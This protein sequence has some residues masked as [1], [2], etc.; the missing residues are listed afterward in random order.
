MGNS[1]ITSMQ[2]IQLI[3]ISRI[4]LAFITLPSLKAAPENQDVWISTALSFFI[5]LLLSIPTYL[6]WIKFPNQSIIQYS[7]T[8]LGNW[9]GGLI[10]FL[11]ICFI[12]HTISLSLSQISMF[13]T[14]AIMPETPDLFFIFSLVL[15]CAY[16]VFKGI[17]VLGRISEIVAPLI[18]ISTIAALLILSKIIQLDSLLPVMEKGVFSVMQGSFYEAGNTFEVLIFAML[19]PNLNDRQKGKTVFIASF[20][21]LVSLL[22]IISITILG[23]WGSN[24]AKSLLFPFAFTLK[25]AEVTDIIERV[26][27]IYISLWTL[28]FFIKISLLYYLSAVGVSH[29][30]NFKEYKH[31]VIPIGSIVIPLSIIMTPNIIEL[32][33]FLSYKTFTLYS[34]VFILFIPT[35]LLITSYIRGKGEKHI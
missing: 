29:L 12:I 5:M 6:L 27:I 31:F 11:I 8:L 30:F 33:E 9:V 17:E 34:L 24:E 16:A 35:I 2:F 4:I 32:R 1:K 14:S 10:G 15:C 26:E 3:I 23:I 13:F 18:I 7:K 28:G 20:L 25:L 19:L 22:L 21:I